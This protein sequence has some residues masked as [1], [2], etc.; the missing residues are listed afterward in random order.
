MWIDNQT[1]FVVV[2]NM[3]F[4][5]NSRL[6]SLV[7]IVFEFPS[8]G[9]IFMTTKA[10]SARLYPYVNVWDFLVLGAQGIFILI[11]FISGILLVY[12][13]WNLKIR[14]LTSLNFLGK[15]VS[16]GFAVA[17]VVMYV[18]RIDRT[19]YIVEEIMNSAGNYQPNQ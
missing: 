6:F 15:F 9:G 5:P 2:E 17:A 13:V 16:V 7:S 8:M 1:R 3:V 12:D 18:I 19:V 14:C 11:T 4:N 10:Q